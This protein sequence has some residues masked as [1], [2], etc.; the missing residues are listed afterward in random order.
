MIASKLTQMLEVAAS[1]WK[2]KAPD[3]GSLV[4]PWTIKPFYGDP[5]DD[6]TWWKL[7]TTIE[8]ETIFSRFS[9]KNPSL[10]SIIEFNT[11][12]PTSRTNYVFG[13]SKEL[14]SIPFTIKDRWS[15]PSRVMLWTRDGE[16]YVVAVTDEVKQL[17]NSIL[18]ER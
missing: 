7:L 3:S 2:T 18:H 13:A 9:W 1:R 5:Y 15:I 17:I 16:Y 6:V 8:A 12:S 4:N 10:D 11:L 14:S